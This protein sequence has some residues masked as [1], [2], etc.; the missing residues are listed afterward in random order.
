[1]WGK[2]DQGNTRQPLVAWETIT[3]RN[4]NVGLKIQCFKQQAK[5][6]KLKNATKLMSGHQSEWVCIALGLIKSVLKTGPNK[7][8][9]RFWIPSEALLLLNELEMDSKTVNIILRGWFEVRPKL[10]FDFQHDFIPV[11]LSIKQALLLT[12]FLDERRFEEGGGFLPT[13]EQGAYS[14]SETFG[15]HK[16]AGDWKSRFR[17]YRAP[18]GSLVRAR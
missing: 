2:N 10:S 18:P 11:S 16:V 1:M 9:Q 17:A 3:P 15:H 7:K 13:S 4:V 14:R 5:L 8:E 6:L 12:W